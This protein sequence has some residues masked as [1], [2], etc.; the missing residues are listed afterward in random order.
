MLQNE[1]GGWLRGDKTDMLE[2]G[3]RERER[4]RERE[5]LSHHAVA[6]RSVG[7][8]WCSWTFAWLCWSDC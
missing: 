8:W 6:Q 5:K 3:K 2:R 4:E 1:Q 7:Q